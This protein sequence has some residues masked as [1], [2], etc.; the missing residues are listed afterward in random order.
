M[1][2]EINRKIAVIFVAN[3]VGYPKHMEVDQNENRKKL[4]KIKHQPNI[5]LL[6]KTV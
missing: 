6:V 4:R 5:I 2:A 3:V 1:S